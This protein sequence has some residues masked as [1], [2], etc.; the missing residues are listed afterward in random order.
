MGQPRANHTRDKSNQPVQDELDR[1]KQGYLQSQKVR[2]T[3][4]V[5]LSAT[6]SELSHEGRTMKFYADL[7]RKIGDLTL[8][9]VA[10]A[11]RK[12][13]HPQNLVIVRAGDFKTKSPA[14]DNK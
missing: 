1:A 3:S 10:A 6:L 13:L 5:G 11:V 9:Q 2:R 7:E 12:H 4:D 8:Q 14:T